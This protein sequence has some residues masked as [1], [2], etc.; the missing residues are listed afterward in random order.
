[1][2]KVLCRLG[3]LAWALSRLRFLLVY[4]LAV[5]LLFLLLAMRNAFYPFSFLWVATN[6]CLRQAEAAW[7]ESKSFWVIEFW[8]DVSKAW[9]YNL[10]PILFFYRLLHQECS[11]VNTTT[12]PSVWRQKINQRHDERSVTSLFSAEHVLLLS[13]QRLWTLYYAW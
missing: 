7:L 8:E 13:L 5:L 12:R 3:G 1:M 6:L 2:K 11:S 10:E 4:D 9:D